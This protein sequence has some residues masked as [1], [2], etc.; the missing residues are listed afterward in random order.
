MASTILIFGTACKQPF[1]VLVGTGAASTVIR[2]QVFVD[3]LDANLQS[4]FANFSVQEKVES[5]EAP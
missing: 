3:G 4:T 5:Q 2:E 1:T